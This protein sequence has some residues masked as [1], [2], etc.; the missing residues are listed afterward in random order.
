MPQHTETSGTTWLELFVLFDTS[1][2]RSAKGDHVKDLKAADRAAARSAK[3]KK[4]K[5][6]DKKVGCKANAVILPTLAEEIGRFKAIARHIVKHDTINRDQAEW[7][8]MEERAH[9]KR[10]ADLGVVGNQPAIAA[11]VQASAETKCY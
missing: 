2:A 7:F 1:G 3:Y 5:L 6:N 8:K 11:V 9:L 10:L 4:S